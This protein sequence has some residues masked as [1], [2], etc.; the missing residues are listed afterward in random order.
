MLVNTMSELVGFEFPENADQK[1]L[2]KKLNEH[3]GP[4]PLLDCAE[5]VDHASVDNPCPV[6]SSYFMS[7]QMRGYDRMR[8]RH[9][10][11]DPL[12]YIQQ[13]WAAPENPTEEE[14]NAL[15]IELGIEAP[16]LDMEQETIGPLLADDSSEDVNLVALEGADPVDLPPMSA[17][18]FGVWQVA[19]DEETAD[20]EGE[21]SVDPFSS[22]MAAYAAQ[23]SN[24]STAPLAG[25][26]GIEQ[27][28]S[29]IYRPHSG[30]I[31]P[32][33]VTNV[34]R[35]TFIHTT[36]MWPSYNQIVG[37]GA[38]D[39]PETGAPGYRLLRSYEKEIDLQPCWKA[40]EGLKSREIRVVA[41]NA[42]TCDQL[43]FTDSDLSRLF[44]TTSRMNMVAEIPELYLV[45]FASPTG[46]VVIV[47]PTRLAEQRK[48]VP[49]YG[50]KTGFR[51]ECVLPRASDEKV[52]RQEYRP[53]HG[54]AVGPVLQDRGKG[55][56]R[57]ASSELPKRYR[58]MLHYR[59][60]DILSY[61]LSR[62]EETQRVGIF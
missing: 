56:N 29:M 58:L 31:T 38:A 13:M 30:V 15:D 3:G 32:A 61:E 22:V 62:D 50:C 57:I 11:F 25:E 51:V 44:R 27:G 55:G 37:I 18:P 42:L 4:T 28:T 26:L 14:A 36:Q 20:E 6:S 34:E 39:R 9:G 45:I 12:E 59:N 35:K 43:R 41:S 54:M 16:W 10:G 8:A 60:H 47:T 49:G 2:R 17:L 52:Y 5:G 1:W 46:R 48:L 19:D 53:L 21:A 33:P 40:Y 24:R 23:G 7:V